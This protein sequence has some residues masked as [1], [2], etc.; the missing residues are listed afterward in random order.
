M[1]LLLYKL[2]VKFGQLKSLHANNLWQYYGQETAN[3]KVINDF[4]TINVINLFLWENLR[5]NMCG[6]MNEGYVLNQVFLEN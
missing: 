5:L 2:K 1:H 6:Y 3:E 4:L